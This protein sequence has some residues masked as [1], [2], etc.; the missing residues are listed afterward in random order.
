MFL[1]VCEAKQAIKNE[2]VFTLV[3]VI[4]YSDKNQKRKDGFNV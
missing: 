3:C 4:G 2:P 1:I